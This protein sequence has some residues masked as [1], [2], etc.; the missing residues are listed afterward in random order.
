MKKYLLVACMMLFVGQAK[1]AA[2][3]GKYIKN[4]YISSSM[5]PSFK[6]DEGVLEK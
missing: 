6:I 1:P 4:V 2:A 5:G 3:K